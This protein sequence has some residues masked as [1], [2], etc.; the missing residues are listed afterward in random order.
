MDIKTKAYLVHL[1]T[2]TGAV[3]GAGGDRD[4]GKRPEMGRVGVERADVCVLTSDNPR[5]E[6]PRTILDEV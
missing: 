3:F 4:K 2:A 5:T 1:L 6:D